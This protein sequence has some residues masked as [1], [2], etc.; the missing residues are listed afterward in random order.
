MDPQQLRSVG[1]ILV[2][3]ASLRHVAR[4]YDL[5]LV[6]EVAALYDIRRVIISLLSA[7]APLTN[8]TTSISSSWISQ[9]SSLPAVTITLINKRPFITLS[10]A[11]QMCVANLQID[12]WASSTA[13]AIALN[14]AIY[15]C[16]EV[17]TGIVEGTQIYKLYQ[18]GELDLSESPRDSSDKWTHRIKSDWTVQ[19]KIPPPSR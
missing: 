19:Y 4:F 5:E 8:L 13:T 16:L 1:R 2:P 3:G 7:F 9:R 6:E 14:E 17:R 10:G 12:S 15:N 18:T 11:T